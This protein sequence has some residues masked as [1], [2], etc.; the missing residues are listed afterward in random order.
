MSPFPSR[1]LG[2]DE[3]VVLVLHPLWK[4]IVVPALLLPIVV[5]VAR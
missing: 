3:E 5:G 2:D 4:R 1:L